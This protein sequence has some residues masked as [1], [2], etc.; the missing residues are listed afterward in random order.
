M[1]TVPKTGAATGVSPSHT[2]DLTRHTVARPDVP[3]VRGSAAPVM[4]LCGYAPSSQQ[5]T[6]QEVFVNIRWPHQHWLIF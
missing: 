1:R 2:A 4:L 3:Q 6:F 5:V